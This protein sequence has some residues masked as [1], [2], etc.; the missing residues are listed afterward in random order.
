MEGRYSRPSGSNG[1]P[2]VRRCC[3]DRPVRLCCNGHRI[4]A[5]NTMAKKDCFFL[6]ACT[7]LYYPLLSVGRS[8]ALF[9]DFMSLASPV[10]NLKMIWRISTHM[11]QPPCWLPPT[12]V[13][14]RTRRTLL[15]LPMIFFFVDGL[16]PPG[17]RQRRWQPRPPRGFLV[18]VV[19]SLRCCSL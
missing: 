7:R 18:A 13:S 2:R 3:N 12:R 16:P 8:V 6:I 19:Q 11:S 17:R 5:V 14:V 1:R 15:P 9:H 4:V 10:S